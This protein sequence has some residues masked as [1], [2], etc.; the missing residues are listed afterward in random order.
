[1]RKDSVFSPRACSVNFETSA[2][3]GL[4]VSLDAGGLHGPWAAR[5]LDDPAL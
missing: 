4:S 5:P 1:M 2:S 3:G